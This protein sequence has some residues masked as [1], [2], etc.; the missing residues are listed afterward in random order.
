MKAMRSPSRPARAGDLK[1]ADA[2]L[3]LP[4]RAAH[5]VWEDVPVLSR[6][7]LEYMVEPL[8]E[9]FGDLGLNWLRYIQPEYLK[10]AWGLSAAIAS[11]VRGVLKRKLK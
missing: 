2:V 7:E 1:M 10:L 4:F 3:G 11:R 5:L 8:N 6:E 9:I